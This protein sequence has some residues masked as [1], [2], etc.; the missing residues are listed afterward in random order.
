MHAIFN[1]GLKGD[2]SFW[3]FKGGYVK[4]GITNKGGV[5][6]PLRIYSFLLLRCSIDH[7]LSELKRGV[8]R[9]FQGE[10]QKKEVSDPS[11]N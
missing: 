9:I 10:I 3:F 2:R 5:Q 6:T 1:F 4:E 7:V 11:L 8:S